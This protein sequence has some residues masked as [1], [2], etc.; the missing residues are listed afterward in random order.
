MEDSVSVWDSG[1]IRIRIN[2]M[3]SGLRI[4]S[5]ASIRYKFLG[6]GGSLKCLRPSLLT[7]VKISLCSI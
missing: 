7:I 2:L 4:S 3:K 6:M 5:A 1:L